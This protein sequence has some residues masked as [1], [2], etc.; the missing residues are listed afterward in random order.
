MTT[1]DD[2][3]SKTPDAVFNGHATAN[4]IRSCVPNIKDPWKINSID[5]DYILVSI[6]IASN[7]ETMDI[8]SKCPECQ[9]DS[10]YGVD[11]LTILKNQPH[12]DYTEPLKIRDLEVRFRP[13]TYSEIN[14]N[15]IRQYEFQKMFYD[16]QTME[17]SEQKDKM[18]NE[19]VEKMNSMINDILTNTILSIT[20]PETIVTDKDFISEFLNN[21]DK[22]TNTM[23]KNHSV[24][25]RELNKLKPLNLKCIKCSH[26]YS[27]ELVMNISTFFE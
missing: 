15:D 2:I 1:I 3:T 23:I 9:E 13:L 25:L 12:V 7:G 24:K 8:E 5:L 10:D 26:E 19:I 17:Q 21:C 18:S 14:K 22:N 20:T 16:I 27:Q 4:I 11:L 6:R